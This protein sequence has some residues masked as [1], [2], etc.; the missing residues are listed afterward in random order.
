MSRLEFEGL[1]HCPLPVFLYL[2]TVNSF[3]M[4]AWLAAVSALGPIPNSKGAFAP[5][6]SDTHPTD[7]AKRHVQEVTTSPFTYTIVQ[8][9][10]MDGTMCTTLPGVW[11]PYDQTWES[12]R[13]LRLENVGAT[14]VIHPWLRIGPIDFFSQQTIANSVVEGLA[15]EREKALALF[16]FYITHRYHKGNGDNTAQGDVSQ[17]INVFGFNTCGNSTL[18]LSDLLDKVGMRDCLFS[19]CPGHVVP[20]VFFEGRYHTMDGDMAIFM[21]LRDN[22]TLANEIEWVRDHDLIKR[23][24]AYGIMSPMDPLRNNE[25]YAQY[26]TWEG[27]TTVQL[28][29]WAWWNMGMIL[30]PGEAIEWRWG[31]ETPVKYHGDM[32]GHPPIV[33]DTIYNGLWEYTPDFRNDAQWRAG[34]NATNITNTDGVLTATAEGT[35]TIVWPM[36]TPYQ[37]VGGTLFASG[38]GYAFAVGFLDPKDWRKTVYTP[39]ATLAE[40]D[41]VFKGRTAD[42]REYW[43]KC[44]LTGRATLSALSIKNDIQMAPLAMPSMTVGTNRFTYIEHTDNR[45]GAN[46]TRH[47]RIPHSWVERSQTRPPRAPEAPV[48]PAD[49]GE[50]DGTAVRFQWSA[51]TDPDG[52]SITDYHF[53]LSDRPDVRWPLSPNFDKYISKTPDRGQP[54]YTLPRP[55]L[56]TPGLAYY[57]RVKARDANGVWGPWSGT[58]SFTAQGP[59]YPL[60]LAMRYEPERGIGILT[61]KANPVG[62]PPAKYRVYGSDEKGFTVHDT[63]YEVKLGDTRELT[64]PFPANFVAEVAGP[65]LEVIGVGNALP[66]A[67]RAY[68][69]VV[70]VD[71]RDRRSGDS[72]YV[73]APRPFIYSTPVTRAPA[74]QGYRYQV[75]A[76]RSL[77]DL[78][79]RDAAKPRPGTRFWKIEPLAFS[80]T[81]RP[82]WM[83]IDADTGLIAGTSDGT[84]GPVT[85]SVTLTKEHRLVHDQDNIVWGNEHEQSRTYE[86]VG[87][88]TQHFIVQ[89]TD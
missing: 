61:W 1:F 46:T 5:W 2:R 72:D 84:G 47:L 70:A 75:L 49:G 9:G 24:H 10:T 66:N 6:A 29:G 17:A 12:N 28:D 14:K 33:P 11:E 52:D 22:Y 71:A 27:N 37:F 41:G 86:S 8:G 87:P 80:L 20:Q 25:D 59:E 26:Y 7:V 56:L 30:R 45:S 43:L 51:A 40:F 55:G 83:S 48:D 88:V 79:R 64:N 19:H 68:Y 21:L 77:G 50:S 65:S 58:W 62:R 18:C 42:A 38:E 44:T 3:R 4:L 15:T 36:K 81:E 57:W 53:Q 13:S 23:V 82:A 54:A 31:H 16:Y 78:T 76:I 69:R 67:N 74:G 60:D 34:A 35:G 73:E 32:T 85:V 39:L 89:G 63:P